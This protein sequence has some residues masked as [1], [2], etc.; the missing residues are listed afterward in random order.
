MAD[1][2]AVCCAC[3]TSFAKFLAND[4]GLAAEWPFGTACKHQRQQRERAGVARLSMA[5][6]L[7]RGSGVRVERASFSARSGVRWRATAKSSSLQTSTA[8]HAMAGLDCSTRPSLPP[9]AAA[10]GWYQFRTRAQI[11]AARRCCPCVWQPRAALTQATAAR[12][13]L[14]R[15]LCADWAWR[16]AGGCPRP[17]SFRCTGCSAGFGCRCADVRFVHYPPST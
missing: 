5:V 15:G 17:S 7:C 9:P 11:A 8:G 12:S 13:G 16:R 10:R 6:P 14:A 2:P 4:D 3:T 1:W